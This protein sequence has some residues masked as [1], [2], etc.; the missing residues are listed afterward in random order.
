LSINYILC[1][2]RKSHKK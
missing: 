1:V 2:E